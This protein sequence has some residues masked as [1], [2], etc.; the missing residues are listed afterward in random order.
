MKIS[1]VIPT[2][3][4]IETLPEV[5]DAIAS[6]ELTSDCELVAI[7]SGSTDGTTE[8]LR[9]R[10]DRLLEIVPEAFNHGL[11][12]NQAI[13]EC[14][15]ELVVLLVQDAIPASPSWLSELTAPLLH[16]RSLA[17][18]FARQL[19]RPD[20]G[21]LTR[22]ALS[23]WVGAQEQPWLHAVDD[24]ASFLA[25]SPV[26]RY[27]TCVFDNVCSCI[28]RSVWHRHPFPATPIAEDVEWARTVLLAGYRLAYVPSA[29][30]VHSHE[31]SLRYELIRTFQVHHRLRHLFELRTIPS[32]GH[33]LRA[34]LSTTAAHLACLYRHQG[35][36]PGPATILRALGLAI[37]WPAGQYLGARKQSS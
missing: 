3:N 24:R 21:R 15:G 11:T 22:W 6:Q 34:W 10:A 13:A 36:R 23:G 32:F 20:A 27:L 16:D 14:R 26:E 18:T 37:V 9:K 28:R 4:G 31:R 1:I 35:P 17:G 8:L 19:P 5:L 33:L 2:R 12:R 29:M 25:R 30:V 7:D